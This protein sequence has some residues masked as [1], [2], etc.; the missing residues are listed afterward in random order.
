MEGSWI[1]T[2]VS[3]TALANRGL[4]RVVTVHVSVDTECCYWWQL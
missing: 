3:V 1:R 2:L 4:N